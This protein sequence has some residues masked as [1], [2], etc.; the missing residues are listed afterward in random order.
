MKIKDFNNCTE[1]MLTYGGHAGAKLG[2][3]IDG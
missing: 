2:I 3:I 1:N